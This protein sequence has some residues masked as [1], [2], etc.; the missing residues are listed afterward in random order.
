M[1]FAHHLCSAMQVTGARV[2]AETFPLFQDVVD[3]SDGKRV[4][5]WEPIQPALVV[6]DDGFD[7]RLLEH[8][9]RDENAVGIGARTPRQ[10]AARG[11]VEAQQAAA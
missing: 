6:R 3:G 11:I 7:A 8:E 10:I 4:D 1:L 5:V 9:F 2:V